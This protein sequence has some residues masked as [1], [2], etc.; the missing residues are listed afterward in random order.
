[1]NKI[2]Y[3]LLT[4]V[5][6]KRKIKILNLLV[7]SDLPLS[8]SKTAKLCNVSQKTI[9]RD[10]QVLTELFPDAVIFENNS[11]FLNTSA[12]MNLI[13]NY[14]EDE[15]KNNILFSIV[16]DTFYARSATIDSYSDKFFISES[17]LRKYLFLLKKVLKQFDLTLNLSPI[18]ILGDEI[19][20]R[21]FYFHFFE[22]ITEFSRNNYTNELFSLLRNLIN[23]DGLL[24]NVDYHRLVHWSAITEQ[25]IRQNKLVYLKQE[26]YEKHSRNSALPSIKRSMKENLDPVFYNQVNDAEIIFSFLLSLDTIVYDE[27]SYFVPNSFLNEMEYFDHLVNEF[28]QKS[29][30]SYSLNVELKAIIKAFL[31]NE[32]VLQDLS[33]L[34]QKNSSTFQNLM[35]KKHHKTFSIWIDVL[36]D[37]DTFL[38]KE[39]LAASLTSLTEAKVNRNKKVLFALTGTPAETTY[40]K[41]LAHK[42]VPKTADLSFIFNQP[43]DNILIERLDIDV[44]ICNFPLSSTDLKCI[45]I[46]FSN[47]P[48]DKEWES[49]EKRLNKI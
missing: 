10:T 21:Y 7:E 19:N 4:D 24:L 41:Y 13:L 34:F 48:L 44:C 27:K 25:R 2:G 42:Y 46:K 45:F 6:V 31:A 29:N 32:R 39:D 49:L 40:Y 18:E 1:M 14:I 3:N 30:L 43:I 47:V 23:V 20:I 11:L 16:E 26:V 37:N 33:P 9:T 36:E 22:Q 38:Y 17:T 12:D 15:V 35:K 28:F 8:I 5:A